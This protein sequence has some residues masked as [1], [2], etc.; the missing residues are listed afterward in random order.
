[1]VDPQ[2]TKHER[3]THQDPAEEVPSD[4]EEPFAEGGDDPEELSKLHL[5][6]RL[7]VDHSRHV[8]NDNL[9]APDVVLALEKVWIRKESHVHVV[10]RTGL[11][12]R[13][14]FEETK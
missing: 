12:G 5:D 4:P 3:D 8:G 10:G 11:P 9:G 2:K 1:M 14:S 13:P 6:S 7:K